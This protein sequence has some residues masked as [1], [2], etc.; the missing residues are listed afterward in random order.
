MTRGNHDRHRPVISD[1]FP[2]RRR[3]NVQPCDDRLSLGGD[4]KDPPP[5]VRIGIIVLAEFQGDLVIARSD[6]EMINRISPP[7]G[8]IKGLLVIHRIADRR[9][10]GGG[11]P[12]GGRVVT[13]TSRTEG[14]I[15][16]P[17][18]S[19]TVHELRSSRIDPDCR[20]R[21]GRDRGRG[22]RTSIKVVIQEI[23][24]EHQEGHHRPGFVVIGPA[25]KQLRTHEVG[26]S[27]VNVLLV[28]ATHHGP[29][30][31]RSHEGSGLET[32]ILGN[33]Q[34]R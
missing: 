13:P 33:G 2:W 31:G 14:L 34:G 24:R 1:V 18:G 27:V 16:R 30:P 25:H 28:G 4:A 17:G 22:G 29:H 10:I 12:R 26:V 3:I 21:I 7:F 32:G 8:L 19:S 15:C 9:G 23:A 11:T 20:G 5:R 6:R